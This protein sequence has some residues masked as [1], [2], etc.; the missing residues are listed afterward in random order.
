MPFL[1]KDVAIS[2][3]GKRVE[4]GSRIAAG[5]VAAD[6]SNLM[7]HF[8]RARLVTIGRTTSPEMAFSTKTEPLHNGPTRDH[9]P[10]RSFP[11]R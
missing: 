5:H 6:D 1:I 2:M 3:K 11:A 4:L 7:R 8:R 10:A 9:R